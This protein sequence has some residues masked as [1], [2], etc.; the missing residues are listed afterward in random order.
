MRAN[1][2]TP[3][4]ADAR[5]VELRNFLEENLASV[6]ITGANGCFSVSSAA[7]LN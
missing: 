5:V 3:D 6:T 7:G 4:L 2:P 1:Y